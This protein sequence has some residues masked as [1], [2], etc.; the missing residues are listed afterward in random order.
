MPIVA[1]A[2][3]LSLGK[4]F[5]FCI[6]LHQQLMLLAPCCLLAQTELFVFTMMLTR[7]WSAGHPVVL[8]TDDHGVFQTSLSKEYA[9][10]LY[11]F[12]CHYQSRVE[13]YDATAKACNET[14]CSNLTSSVYILS[15]HALESLSL[16]PNKMQGYKCIYRQTWAL[17]E[18]IYLQ[19]SR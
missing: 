1:V 18:L 15:F 10:A 8:C 16:S 6:V 12:V 11:V 5:F 14:S 17:C 2:Q 13:N 19:D 7:A 4:Q 3:A 9:I